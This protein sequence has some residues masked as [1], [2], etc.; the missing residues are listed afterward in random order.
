M[1]VL[2][3][4]VWSPRNLL[5]GQDAA[6]AKHMGSPEWGHGPGASPRLAQGS[7]HPEFGTGAVLLGR[8]SS[9]PPLR[10]C[11]Q[12]IPQ[13]FKVLQS[14]SWGQRGLQGL[15]L[16]KV[17][18]AWMPWAWAVLLHGLQFLQSIGCKCR[19]SSFGAIPNNY[20]ARY[21]SYY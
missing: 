11:Q 9:S 12:Q 10:E 21:N 7:F 2:R 5:L 8:A 13:H 1:S 18:G 20:K 14:L 16:G 6:F 19:I 15:V 4:H 3:H 17:S